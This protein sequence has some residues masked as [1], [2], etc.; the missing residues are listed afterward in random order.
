M[1][2]I[3]ER[4]TL[5]IGINFTIIL[6]LLYTSLII[7]RKWSYQRVCKYWSLTILA[8]IIIFLYLPYIFHKFAF[9]INDLP[10]VN[11][12]SYSLHA[13]FYA[14]ILSYFLTASLVFA[15]FSKNDLLNNFIKILLLC[16]TL[17]YMYIIHDVYFVL[18]K[19]FSP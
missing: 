4:I 19:Y 16:F 18:E 13:P 11:A 8:L 17:H 2:N 3:I 15:D 7:I 14:L 10:V 1:N 12:I 9:L 6:A 5:I